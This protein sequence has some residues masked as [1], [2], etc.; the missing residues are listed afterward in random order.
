[1]EL[2]SKENE[3]L[4]EAN[5]E[6][7]RILD[8]SLS[9]EV[10]KN[11]QLNIEIAQLKSYS[12]E[13]AAALEEEKRVKDETLLR[14]AEISQMTQLTQQELKQQQSQNE[15]LYKKISALEEQQE[16]TQQVDDV[17]SYQVVICYK[18]DLCI[19]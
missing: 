18:I 11:N 13:L 12:Q 9:K 14:N 19:A 16:L 5:E 4:R 6:S 15:E 3:A 8:D 7:R 10:A 1:M 17:Q 2:L